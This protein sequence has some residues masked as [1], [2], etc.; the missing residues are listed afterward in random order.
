MIPLPEIPPSQKTDTT[1]DASDP[2]LSLSSTPSLTVFPAVCS[3]VV[4]GDLR[5][6]GKESSF[7]DIDVDLE[8]TFPQ[9][10][11]FQRECAMHNQLRHILYTYCFFRPDIGYIQSMSFICGY[12]LLYMPP[13]TAFF[14]FANL[15]NSPFFHAF[16]KFDLVLIHARYSFFEDLLKEHASSLHSHLL[17]LGVQP[18]LY[19]LEWCMTLFSKR[20]KLDVI[21]RVFDLFIFTGEIAVYR[22]SLAIL[23]LLKTS[24]M[25]A[26]DLQQ[27]LSIISNAPISLDE[28]QLMAQVARI[29]CSDKMITRLTEIEQQQ[30]DSVESETTSLS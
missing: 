6:Y 17:D 8:R 30:H 5:A 27:A 1:D 22:I 15:L 24:L 20:L 10:A 3:D 7:G 9:L 2:S 26:D 14:C 12:F 19:L 25:Q 4:L 18:D 21:G 23:L 11:F 16:L 29:H 13:Y 28:N